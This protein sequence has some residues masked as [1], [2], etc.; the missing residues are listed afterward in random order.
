VKT[1]DKAEAQAE[2]DK[3]VEAAKEQIKEKYG[4]DQ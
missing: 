4:V 1:E 2:L 3:M